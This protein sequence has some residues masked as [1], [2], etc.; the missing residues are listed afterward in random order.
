MNCP[1][2]EKVIYQTMQSIDCCCLANEE[3]EITSC[4]IIG[5]LIFFLQNIDRCGPY[6]NGENFVLSQNVLRKYFL[7][8]LSVPLIKESVSAQF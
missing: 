5:K 6:K 1:A 2:S 7:S 4:V 8:K 3:C